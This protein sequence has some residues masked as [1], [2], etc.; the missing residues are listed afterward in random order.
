MNRHPPISCEPRWHDGALIRRHLPESLRDWL[1]DDSSLTR[2][3]QQACSGRFHVE[4][5]SL[6]WERP[7]LDEA[8]AMRVPPWQRALVRQVRLWCDEQPWVFARTVIPMSSL[9]GAQR[10]LAHLGSR[11]LGAFLFADPAL[12]R[13][14]MQVARICPGSRLLTA[15]AP[16]PDAIWGRRSVFRLQGHPLL[17]SEFFLPALPPFQQRNSHE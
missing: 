6:G 1:L 16:S 13:S 10:R 4:L 2:R 5:I 8:Q 3:L 15:A 12:Q 7:L 11:P 17:V 9:R 14:P